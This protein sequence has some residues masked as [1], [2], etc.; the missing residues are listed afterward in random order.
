MKKRLI[1]MPSGECRIGGERTTLD[2]A[3]D[4]FCVETLKAV[5]NGTEEIPEVAFD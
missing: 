2:N 5:K 4:V 3:I 1:A